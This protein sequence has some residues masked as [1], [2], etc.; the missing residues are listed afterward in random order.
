M[1]LIEGRVPKPD[2]QYAIVVPALKVGQRAH[3]PFTS[4]INDTEIGLLVEMKRRRNEVLV[5]MQPRFKLPSGTEES[6]SPQGQTRAGRHLNM[7]AV[8]FDAAKSHVGLLRRYH[9]CEVN[10]QCEL[11]IEQIRA[12]EI[13]AQADAAAL[14]EVADYWRFVAKDAS[15]CLRLSAGEQA[16]IAKISY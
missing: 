3:V 5:E 13:W 2:D 16:L 7:L 15:I 11:L 14:T 6:F 10:Q 1:A 4:G 12:R 8:R 9:G